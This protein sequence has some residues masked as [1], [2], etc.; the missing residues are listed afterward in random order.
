MCLTTCGLFYLR[1]TKTG[2]TGGELASGVVTDRA[3][4]SGSGKCVSGGSRGGSRTAAEVGAMEGCAQ[5]E[6]A[7]CSCAPS[8]GGQ[9]VPIRKDQVLCDREVQGQE[10]QW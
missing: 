8:G 2:S 4:G 10:G 7:Q 3:E 9:G 5:R 6:M 1:K